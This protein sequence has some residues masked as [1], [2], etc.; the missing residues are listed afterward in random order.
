MGGDGRSL[1][2]ALLSNYIDEVSLATNIGQCLIIVSCHR[3]TKKGNKME[4]SVVW[5]SSLG[6]CALSFA[7]ALIF[8]QMVFTLSFPLSL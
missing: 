3:H 7:Y 4:I 5:V 6:L 2:C 1:M 8:V